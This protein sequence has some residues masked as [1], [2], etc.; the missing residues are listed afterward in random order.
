MPLGPKWL[1]EQCLRGTLEA[2]F[3]HQ[4]FSFTCM[5]SSLK[6]QMSGADVVQKAVLCE[7][8]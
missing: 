8:H 6:K 1:N 3:L 7:L 4:T 2:Q 5:N